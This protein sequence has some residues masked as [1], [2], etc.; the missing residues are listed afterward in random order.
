MGTPGMDSDTI[1]LS[2]GIPRES[3]CICDRIE[4][5]MGHVHRTRFTDI[6]EGELLLVEY[7][8]RR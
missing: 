1:E 7:D 3:I 6:G 5:G 8:E 4:G 2:E